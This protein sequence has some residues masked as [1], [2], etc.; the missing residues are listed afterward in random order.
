MLLEYSVL[1]SFPWTPAGEHRPLT[2][3]DYS[4]LFSLSYTPAGEHRPLTLLDYSLLFSLSYTPAVVHSPSRCLTTHHVS[5]FS[6]FPAAF[7]RPPH[8]LL[9]QLHQYCTG[10]C[11]P[12]TVAA[13]SRGSVFPVSCSFP[14]LAQLVQFSHTPHFP[15]SP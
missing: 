4:Q 13:C 1:V 9:S 10:F 5:V 2:L 15:Q 3:P 14:E 8:C 11:T 6:A 12:L 7:H